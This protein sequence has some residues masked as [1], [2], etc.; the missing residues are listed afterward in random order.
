MAVNKPKGYDE[1]QVYGDWER[2]EPGGH[3]LVI[4][5]VRETLTKAGNAAIEVK[6]DTDKTDKQ[7]YYYTRI[8]QNDSRQNKRFGGIQI[9]PLE[10]DGEATKSLKSFCTA[11]EASNSGFSVQWGKN[12]CESLK[13]KKIGGVFREVEY[14]KD[15]DVKVAVN[16]YYFR[17]IT[18]VEDVRVPAVKEL[19]KTQSNSDWGATDID[20]MFADASQIDNDDLPF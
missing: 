19:V 13:G 15:G 3:K 17:K 5:T 14:E 9:I 8:Y 20:S 12:F 11:V 6:Y 16:L 2:L 1:V 4:G 18:G 10:H 7:P